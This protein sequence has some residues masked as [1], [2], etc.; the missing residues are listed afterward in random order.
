[1]GKGV[2]ANQYRW[3]AASKQCYKV[4]SLFDADK[5]RGMIGRATRVAVRRAAAV[6]AWRNVA[7]VKLVNLTKV[8]AFE[9]GAL[10][11]TVADST[12]LHCLRQQTIR[13][14]RRMAS[15]LSGVRRIR[16]A[17]GRV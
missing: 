16:F 6:E 1:M 11:I 9:A 3:V 10:L 13:L 15:V 14:Q 17:L 7:P 4:C 2:N 8:E 12:A 5:V